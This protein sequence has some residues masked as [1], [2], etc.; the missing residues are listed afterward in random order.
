MPLATIH[1]VALS[2]STSL[3]SYLHTLHTSIPRSKILTTSKVVRWIITPTTIDAQRLL[4]PKSPWML[5]IIIL[6]TDPLPKSLTSEVLLDHWTTV[7]GIPSRL[8]ADFARTN[9]QLLHPRPEAIPTL[10]GSLDKPRVGTTSQTLELSP[11]LL[12]WA[13]SFRKTRAGSSPLSMLN[14]LAFKQGLKPSY[15]KYGAAFA[16]SIGK[17]RGGVAKLVGNIVDAD[18][19]GGEGGKGGKWDEFALASYP[20]VLHFVD[21]LAGEDYQGVNLKYRVPALEDTLILC[22]S[23]IEVEDVLEAEGK[24]GKAKL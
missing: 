9:D 22:T 20:S 1:L 6:G 18:E 12:E 2:P 11:G 15:L 7:A 16:E 17:R 4:N 3:P 5:L 21:M 10:T 13:T 19:K 24:G 14:L 23:E 8:T